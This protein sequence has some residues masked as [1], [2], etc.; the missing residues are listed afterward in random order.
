M[1]FFIFP[2]VLALLA[3]ASSAKAAITLRIVEFTS[4][5]FTVS[6]SG[7][8]EKN[9]DKPTGSGSGFYLSPSAFAI[10]L[11]SSATE[12]FYTGQPTLLVS[13]LT[14]GN[15]PTNVY[16]RDSG[17]GRFELGFSSGQ[18]FP[19]YAGTALGGSATFTGNFNPA[20]AQPQDFELW[21]GIDVFNPNASFS[22][23][24][25]NAVPE[26]SALAMLTLGVL[27]CRRTR[28]WAGNRK[29]WNGYDLRRQQGMAAAS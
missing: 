17:T 7:T 9:A 15:L 16:M 18:T 23:Y 2:A 29:V 27:V 25:V 24:H 22:V 11:N 3:A 12:G 4:T 19:V 8:L 1:R 5:T 21:S 6:L 20:A 26:P 10:V 28:R 14:Q 13:T